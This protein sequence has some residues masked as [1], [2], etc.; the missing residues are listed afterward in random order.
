MMRDFKVQAFNGI[1]R[2]LP[3]K[4]REGNGDERITI[5]E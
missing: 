3:K 1:A 4:S 2:A 5:T